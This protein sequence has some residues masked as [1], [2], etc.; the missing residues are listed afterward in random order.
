MVE[1]TNIGGDQTIIRDEAIT[2]VIGGS[3]DDPT[4]F[5]KIHGSFGPGVVQTNESAVALVDRLAIPLVKLTRPND[6]PVWVKAAAVATIRPPLS[7]ELLDPPRLVRSV[8]MISGFHQALREDVA[9]ASR[10]L[11]ITGN[12]VST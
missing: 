5:T 1:I 4:P 7:T 11:G 10:L 8:V 12:S 3:A 6:T 9:T 2:V